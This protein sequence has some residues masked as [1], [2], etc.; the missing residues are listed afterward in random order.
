MIA[1]VA[2]LHEWEMSK[3]T[4]VRPTST[5][6]RVSIVHIIYNWWLS[7]TCAE[8]TTLAVDVACAAPSKTISYVCSKDFLW[9]FLPSAPPY[10]V[11]ALSIPKYPSKTLLPCPEFPSI[12]PLTTL[13]GTNSRNRSRNR[14]ASILISGK[15]LVCADVVKRMRSGT[16]GIRSSWIEKVK[17][18]S[19]L[20]VIYHITFGTRGSS[21][22][23]N[24]SS[25]FRT[26]AS[27]A[28]SWISSH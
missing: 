9:S 2:I 8:R 10:L 6:K 27:C 1:A 3:V 12:Q 22:L 14:T 7:H 16:C 18:G 28:Y 26:P 24:E 11:P 23:R 19:S 5:A 21:Q 17:H 25:V 4:S 15:I 20:G 13:S